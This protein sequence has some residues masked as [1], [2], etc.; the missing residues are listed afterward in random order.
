[1]LVL[2]VW[3]LSMIC[4]VKLVRIMSGWFLGRFGMFRMAVVRVN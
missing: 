4:L 1:M 3:A 2:L